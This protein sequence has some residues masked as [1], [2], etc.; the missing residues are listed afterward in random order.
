MG[1]RVEGSNQRAAPL[2]KMSLTHY[3]LNDYSPP[4][5]RFFEDM[6]S[7]RAYRQGQQLDVF[8]PR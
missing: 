7:N 5:D 2:S 3:L 8:R 1:C 4:I 6:F